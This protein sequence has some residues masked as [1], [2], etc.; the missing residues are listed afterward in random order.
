MK[1]SQ[2]IRRLNESQ[3]RPSAEVL[4]VIAVE[5]IVHDYKCPHCNEMIHEKGTYS[6]DGGKTML[7]GL[8]QNPIKFPEPD[9]ATLNDLGKAALAIAKAANEQVS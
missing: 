1:H 2:L 7:H 4:P 8:C 5:R 9:P 3:E 6:P